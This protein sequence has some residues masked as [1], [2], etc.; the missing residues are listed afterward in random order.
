[1]LHKCLLIERGEEHAIKCP[2][3]THPNKDI[4]M[5]SEYSF[6]FTNDRAS[7]ESTRVE[8]KFNKLHK[9]E[10]SHQM[11][12]I[13]DVVVDGIAESDATIGMGISTESSEVLRVMYCCN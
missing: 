6:E 10:S 13:R 12:S 4:A 7:M 3:I 1:M 5:E 11:P 9:T 8:A 2:Q